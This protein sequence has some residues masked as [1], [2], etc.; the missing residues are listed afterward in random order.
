MRND[1]FVSLLDHQENR[2][3]KLRDPLLALDEIIVLDAFRK[4]LNGINKK[5]TNGAA[6]A[7]PKDVMMFKGLVIQNLYGVN[8]DQ[9]EYQIEDRCSTQRFGLR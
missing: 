1:L 4:M 2:L 6:E 8:D 5:H 3:D 9:V 7:K